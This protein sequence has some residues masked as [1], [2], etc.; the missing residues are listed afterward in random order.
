[1][2]THRRRA[3]YGDEPK[4]RIERRD[5]IDKPH[6]SLVPVQHVIEGLQKELFSYNERIVELANEGHQGLA[7]KVLKANAMDL[8]R[9]IDELRCLLGS[10]PI[11]LL[12]GDVARSTGCEARSDC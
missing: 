2:T 3:C 7:M 8:A 9:Q 6:A 10:G 1:M 5:A 11:K 4:T 12:E